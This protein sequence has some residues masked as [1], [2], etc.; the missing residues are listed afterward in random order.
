MIRRDSR[1]AGGQS[2]QGVQDC[3]QLVADKELRLPTTIQGIIILNIGSYGGG[4]H[5]CCPLCPNHRVVVSP[6]LEPASPLPLPP[7]LPFCPLPSLSPLS[8]PSLPLSPSSLP[9]PLPST[10]LHS[11]SSCMA[12]VRLLVNG[13]ATLSLTRTRRA[14]GLAWRHHPAVAHSVNEHA[15]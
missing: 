14:L 11:P 2:A 10:P 3:G 5:P 9:S 6:P 1:L 13:I 7:P 8:P 15:R 12:E 4:R